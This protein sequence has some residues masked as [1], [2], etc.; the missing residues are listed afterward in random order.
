M[1]GLGFGWP[2]GARTTRRKRELEMRIGLT[3]VMA[4]VAAV[5]AG[6][7]C[8][9]QTNTPEVE[10][11]ENKGTATPV[12]AMA[13]GDTISGTCTGVGTAPGINSLDTWEITPTAA[14]TPGLS[15]Y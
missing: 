10:P 1:A 14:A 2:I 4:A 6:P 3:W 15:E 5:L 12:P 7:T 9:A 8:L 13:P 11:N